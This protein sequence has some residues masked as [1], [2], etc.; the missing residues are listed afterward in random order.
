MPKRGGGRRSSSQGPAQKGRQVS[1]SRGSWPHSAAAT[2]AT[3]TPRRRCI[4][5]AVSFTGHPV[6]AGAIGSDGACQC[7]DSAQGGLSRVQP[8]TAMG[9]SRRSSWLPS[10][11]FIGSRS[12]HAHAFHLRWL[13]RC[14][15]AFHVSIRPL[16]LLPP[17]PSPTPPPP[18][19]TSPVALAPPFDPAFLLASFNVLLLL[20]LGARSGRVLGSPHCCFVDLLS[21]DVSVCDLPACFAGERRLGLCRMHPGFARIAA[22]THTCRLARRSQCS[23]SRP[24][25]HGGGEG[26]GQSRLERVPGWHGLV[27]NCPENCEELAFAVRSVRV[28]GKGC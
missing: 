19:P 4:D 8:K 11:S 15:S 14:S 12:G 21:T 17:P 10:T 18:S 26:P 16:A 20:P 7:C 6:P 1:T 3:G 22:T 9:G 5:A 27:G 23:A 13:A 24:W 25:E 28:R 2:L